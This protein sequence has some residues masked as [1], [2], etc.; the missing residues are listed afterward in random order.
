MSKPVFQVGGSQEIRLIKSAF[1][2]D[3][4]TY[5]KD[6]GL[7]K[8]FFWMLDFCVQNIVVGLESWEGKY[9]FSDN[10]WSVLFHEYKNFP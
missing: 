6:L 4:K 9:V 3:I 7:E 5:R 10:K 8:E 2:G 1:N